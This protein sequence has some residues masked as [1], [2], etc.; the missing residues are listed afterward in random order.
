[1]TDEQKIL[2]ASI[3]TGA[4]FVALV[5]VVRLIFEVLP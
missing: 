4:L 2:I 3:A 1:M 5:L